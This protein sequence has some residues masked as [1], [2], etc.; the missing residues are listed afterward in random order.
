[1]EE[2]G[3]NPDLRRI[4]RLPAVVVSASLAEGYD[5]GSALT[6]LNNLAVDNL[7]PEARL[8]YKGLSQ[9]FQDSSAAI[10]LTFGLA[11]I[12]VFLVLAAQ[13]ESWI[14]PLIIMLSVP[15][16]VTGALIALAWSGISLNIYSQIGIIML[17][18]LM[19]KNG[20]LIVEFANQLRD[21][22]YE[23][24]EAILEG[25]SRGREPGG[26]RHGDLGWP[27]FRHHPDSVHYPGLVQPSG[28]LCEILE[29]GGAGAGTPGSGPIR[30]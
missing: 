2:I 3:A 9:E 21:K 27:D 24:K 22:G 4:D 14:H 30:R 17:L 11:F 16:A 15:L 29:R 23:V 18:G 20:I 19:A 12:I 7:P 1:M 26:Y 6:Y 10:Y 8:S 28:P 25:A 13:F 5:L